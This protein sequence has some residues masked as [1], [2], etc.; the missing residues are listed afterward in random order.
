MTMYVAMNGQ[1]QLVTVQEVERG[2]ACGCTCIE[3]GEVLIAR[4]GEQKEHHFAHHSNKESCE[5]RRESLLHLFAK[6]VI[7]E[8][9]GLQMPH[10]PGQ[11]PEV[12]DPSSWWDFEL[13]EEEVW[14]AGYR[15]DL[16]A[17][18]RVVVKPSRTVG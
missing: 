16:I 8:A 14:L 15:P 1:Q 6:Q 10:L 3:C 9:M 5:V 11:P 18:L 13:V 17:H 12:G 7:R 2:L 4:K